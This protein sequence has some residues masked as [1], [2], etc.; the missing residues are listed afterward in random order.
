M[1][2]HTTLHKYIF[3][4]SIEFFE[5]TD[6]DKIGYSTFRYMYVLLYIF[7]YAAHTTLVFTSVTLTS[8]FPIVLALSR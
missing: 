4:S 7:Y 8:E 1:Q 3:T 2:V 5:N 6:L